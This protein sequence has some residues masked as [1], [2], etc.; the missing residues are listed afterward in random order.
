MNDQRPLHPRGED[1]RR[2]RCVA[3]KRQ[4]RHGDGRAAIADPR[5]PA[6]TTA[7]EM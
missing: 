6:R 2:G 4:A 7:V 3:T 1:H 5:I